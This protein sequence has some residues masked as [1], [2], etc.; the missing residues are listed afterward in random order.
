MSLMP[1]SPAWL[2]SAIASNVRE[3]MR[4]REELGKM[5]GA[6]PLLMKPRNGERWNAADRNQL[7]SMLRAASAV[8]PYLVVLALPGSLV[9]LPILAWRL[10]VRRGRRADT[11]QRP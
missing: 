7:R 6:L 11:A 4:L 5:K 10:D 8:S 2:Q 9:L 1:P 3:R